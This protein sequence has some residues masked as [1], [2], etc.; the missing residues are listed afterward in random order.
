MASSG[1]FCTLNPL[2]AQGGGTPD[3]GT[4]SNGNL[5]VAC[6]DT[7]FGTIGVTSGKWYWEFRMVS[8][9]VS[10]TSIG[11]ANQQVNSEPELG[12]NS[13]ASAAGAQL[14]FMYAGSG[15]YNQIIV[16]G[17][18]SSGV[19]NSYADVGTISQN[20]IIGIAADFDNDKW[21]FSTNGSFDDMRSGQNPS[22]GSSPMCSASGGGGLQTIARTAGLTWFP[23]IGN[24]A[25]PTRDYTVNFGQD[26]TFGGAISA[27]GNADDNGFG[28]FKYAP[29][30]GF[31]AMCSANL[32]ISAD[33][34]PAQ[35]DDSYPAKN[36]NVV[37]YTGNQT[38]GRAVTGVGFAPDLVWIKQRV[39]F[40][41]PNILTDTVRG[42]TK[43]IESNVD[44]AEATDSDGLQSFTSD[45]FT[46]GTND[47]YNWTSSHTY[48]A[49]CWKAGGAPT[50]TNSAGAGATPTSG[51]VKIDGSNLGSA[52]AG[53][54]PAT[55]ISANTK[56]G[57]SIITYTGTG[58]NAT[59]AHGL[60]A[61]PDFILTKRLNS[62]QTWGVYHTS[63]GAT[64]YLA[65][66]STASAG[67][68]SS[69]WN[70]TEPTTSVISL[71]TEGRV[72][73]NSQNY[74]AYAWHNVEGY[75][76]F[77][78]YE[79]NANADGTFVYTGF[80]PRFLFTKR[81]ESTGGWRVRDTGRDTYNP[82]DT[83]LWWD[84]NSL[85]YSNSAY[86]ID[87]LSN[88]FKLRTSS[89]DFNASEEWVYGAWGDVPFK[90]NN[91]F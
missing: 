34:D 65:L 67:T 68:D 63:L 47:K 81:T 38:D 21:Y 79:G 77:G 86:S 33:I 51:S 42:A 48:V 24:W 16:A 75:S 44:I 64:K 49:W 76:R 11:W 50:A 85:E 53:S 61:K 25:A 74:V 90:Y 3:I 30:T 28:V 1:N 41:N 26:D 84:S 71:G 17:S 14:V 55:K 89:N 78:S 69:F 8:S 82:S 32:P 7:A 62:S 52:L 2:A 23:A 46:L 73:G 37:P 70:D 72:N 58:S 29:P 60:T 10:G 4:L 12:Y 9:G 20:D 59:I 80:R 66:N 54:I 91:T 15:G 45:G 88:G 31:L 35:T 22:T 39:S 56:G 87:I 40:S 6:T 5:S 19:G 83:I 57:F 36:F 18:P 13:P 43:R 27:E